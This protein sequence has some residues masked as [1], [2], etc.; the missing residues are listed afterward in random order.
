MAG[1]KEKTTE[2]NE[3]VETNDA[4][5]TKKPTAAQATKAV[6]ALLA[7]GG[8]NVFATVSESVENL[9]AAKALEVLPQLLDSVDNTYFAIGGIMARVH[10]ESWWKDAG[11][12]SFRDYVEEEC[13]QSYRTTMYWVAIYNDLIKA[14]VPF[15]AVADIG[16][17]KLKEI[18]K[19]LKP[20]NY[21]EWLQRAREMSLKQLMEYVKAMQSG[22]SGGNDDGDG[23]NPNVTDVK[24]YTFK[25]H[26]DQKLSVDAAVQSCMEQIGTEYPAVAITHICDGF[27]AGETGTGKA[28]NLGDSMA[29]VGFEKV[30]EEF[31]KQFP[32]VD[33]EV[34]VN[35]K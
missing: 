14:G 8:D 6:K 35:S 12:E 17:S 7:I 25:L 2:T 21:E 31:E 27:N 15:E 9:T 11:F 10:E 23:V 19:M 28:A 13:G 1:T 32:H 34:T 24:P 22:G 16:W 18:S 33:L 26:E 20:D 4:P 30:L 5:K 3:V 29:A